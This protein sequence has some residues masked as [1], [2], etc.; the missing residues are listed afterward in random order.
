MTPSFLQ[1]LIQAVIALSIGLALAK[2]IRYVRDRYVEVDPDD[3]FDNLINKIPD[4]EET[5]TNILF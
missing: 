5:E 3:W 1:T 4:D 2:F